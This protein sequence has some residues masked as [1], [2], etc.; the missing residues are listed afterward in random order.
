[1]HNPD[2]SYPFKMSFWNYSNM[3]YVH[4]PHEHLPHIDNPHEHFSLKRVHF[5][6]CYL[7]NQHWIFKLKNPLFSLTR[8]FQKWGFYQPPQKMRLSAHHIDDVQKSLLTKKI[9]V[10]LLTWLFH[11]KNSNETPS[12]QPERKKK[13]IAQQILSKEKM[14]SYLALLSHVGTSS[15]WAME[16]LL[17]IGPALK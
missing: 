17:E 3:I 15:N 6:V 14:W 10:T 1:M 12:H 16:S 9:P 11:I 13:K 4:N 2:K 5:R 8:I 7:P